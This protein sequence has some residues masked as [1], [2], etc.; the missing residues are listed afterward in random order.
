MNIALWT[1]TNHAQ[2]F[3]KG[4]AYSVEG[5]RGGY[6]AKN[7]QSKKGSINMTYISLI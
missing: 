5:A 6:I 7:L 1:I 2:E 3:E 4:G